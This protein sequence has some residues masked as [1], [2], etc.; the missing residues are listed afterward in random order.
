MNWRER[1]VENLDR[2]A[3]EGIG[4]FDIP[5]LKPVHIAPIEMVGFNFAPKHPEPNKVGVHFFL[6]DYQFQRVWTSPEVYIRML[7]RFQCVC[8]PDF[9]MYTDYPLAVQIYNHYRKHWLGRWW[10]ENGMTVIPTISWSDEKSFDWC[11]DGDPVGGAVAV[12]S[13]GTQMDQN[14][15]RLFLAGYSEMLR[16]LEPEIILFHGDIPEGCEGNI[17]PMATYQKRLRRI[18]PEVV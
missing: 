12:S 10:Q 16:R 1:C 2:A 4:P 13:V 17:V 6:S 9:S 15:R 14:S 11:F 8:T 3:F 7:A 18:K 5:P